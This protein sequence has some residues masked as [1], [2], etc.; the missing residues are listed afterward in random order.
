MITSYKGR[1]IDYNQVVQIYKNLTTGLWSI[2]QGGK[3]VA[4]ANCFLI[5]STGFK[6]SEATRQRVITERK[7]YVHAYVVGHLVEKC[8]LGFEDLI[9]DKRITYNPFKSSQFHFVDDGHL[10]PINND[11]SQYLIHGGSDHLHL[12]KYVR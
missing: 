2:K 4:H 12:V 6:V 8:P 7:K 9:L 3:V 1:E 5:R 10:S 11:G